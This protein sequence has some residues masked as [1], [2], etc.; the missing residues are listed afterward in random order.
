M[1]ISFVFTRAVVVLLFVGFALFVAPL[2]IPFGQ[3]YKQSLAVGGVILVATA[4]FMA[5]RVRC[6]RCQPQGR[7]GLS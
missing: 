4:G 3:T 1:R 6:L 5:I 7:A 2:F